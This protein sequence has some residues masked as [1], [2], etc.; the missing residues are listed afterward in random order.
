MTWLGIDPGISGAW[1]L[2]DDE[3]RIDAGDLPVV[4]GQIDVPALARLVRAAEPHAAV[5]ERVG[6]M[7]G[8][9]VASTFK[10]GA[11]YGDARATIMTLGVRTHFV[12][13]TKWKRHFSLSK[14]KEASRALAIRMWPEADCFSRKKDHGRAEAALIALWASKNI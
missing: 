5:I 14:D 4:D 7:P 9:G 10:F 1:A 11:A 6:S 2:L 8:Q 3:G 12:V 13:P